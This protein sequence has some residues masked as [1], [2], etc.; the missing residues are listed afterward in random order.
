MSVE[1]R[2]IEVLR[3]QLRQD[4]EAWIAEVQGWADAAAAAGDIPREK[5]HREH[6][7]RLRAMTYP[8]EER[9]AA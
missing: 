8:W 6:V 3:A 4:H 5:R 1:D 7:M 2:H 9:R